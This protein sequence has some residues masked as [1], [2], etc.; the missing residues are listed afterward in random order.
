MWLS[1]RTRQLPFAPVCRLQWY[2]MKRA[3]HHLRTSSSTA[4]ESLE[5][6]KFDRRF[7]QD[8]LCRWHTAAAAAHAA[9]ERKQVRSQS[10]QQT[11]LIGL[12][13]YVQFFI[14]PL[15]RSVPESGNHHADPSSIGLA[16]RKGK[17]HSDH[18]LS[19]FSYKAE[20]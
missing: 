7:V 6:R 2:N 16:R 18:R 14:K 17:S 9:Q 11:K 15:L 10:V 4:L 12:Q 1:P 13:L 19:A 20:S 8:F 3:S 5:P